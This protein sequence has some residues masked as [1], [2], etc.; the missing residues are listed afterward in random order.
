VLQRGESE[1]EIAGERAA[2][3]RPIAEPVPPVVE[4]EETELG[5]QPLVG[6]QAAVRLADESISGLGV[7][8]REACGVHRLRQAACEYDG[9]KQSSF[10]CAMIFPPRA[11]LGEE[12]G[13]LALGC[14]GSLDMRRI[15]TSRPAQ[16]ARWRECRSVG[17]GDDGGVPRGGVG[18]CSAHVSFHQPAIRRWMLFT[19]GRHFIDPEFKG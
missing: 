18:R 14:A 7:L 2:K 4:V 8:L 6:E 9:S 5:V 17:G 15:L 3:L 12:G 1:P 19:H 13:Q 10:R 11:P 16:L